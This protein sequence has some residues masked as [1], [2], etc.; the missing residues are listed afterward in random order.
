MAQW[1]PY[2]GK[3]REPH[4]KAMY[5]KTVER[6]GEQRAYQVCMQS[7]N[8]QVFPNLLIND[9]MSTNI[10]TCYPVEPG[11]VEVSSWCLGPGRGA[12]GGSARGAST[13]SSPFSAQAAL[14]APT[15]WR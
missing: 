7:G 13:I 1:A 9:L 15:I 8:L 11:F 6:L 14:P 12:A 3:E 2:F 4:F 5:R 10:R